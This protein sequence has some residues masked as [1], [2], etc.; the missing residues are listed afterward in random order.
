MV[1]QRLSP[2]PSKHLLVIFVSTLIAVGLFLWSIRLE[3]S[4]PKKEFEF[5]PQ[6][7]LKPSAR[8]TPETTPS[9][10]PQFL[11]ELLPSK[12]DT[13]RLNNVRSLQ[14]GLECYF[15]VHG[16][17]PMTIDW[18]NPQKNLEVCWSTTNFA[19][20]P[21]GDL[22]ES[23]GEIWRKDQKVGSYQYTPDQEGNTYTI[24]IQGET[25][26]LTIPGPQ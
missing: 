6:P 8:P 1:S 12:R 19:N 3:P 18:T 5:P 21:E 16:T 9:P 14:V 20:Q 25:R 23:G 17:Y 4:Q 22:V 13:Q 26:T 24:T 11:I 15:A 7:T 2:F 10:D